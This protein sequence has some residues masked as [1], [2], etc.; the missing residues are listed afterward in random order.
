MK[1][2]KL[3]CYFLLFVTTSYFL[4]N[5]YTYT[6]TTLTNGNWVENFFVGF[7]IA[8]LMF[9]TTSKFLRQCIDYINIDEF[10]SVAQDK[11]NIKEDIKENIKEK[12]EE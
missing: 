10:I 8:L 9:V 1:F 4:T 2:L 11:T 5:G 7:V 6:I 12:G 3:F